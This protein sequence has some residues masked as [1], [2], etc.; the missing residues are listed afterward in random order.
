MIPGVASLYQQIVQV[1]WNIAFIKE[2]LDDILKGCPLH[3]HFMSHSFTD[4][5][6][7][8]PF[9]LSVDNKHVVLLAEEYS[10]NEHKGNIVRLVVNRKDYALD[11]RQMI[12]CH[13]SH[14]SFPQIVRNGNDFQILPENTSEGNVSLFD[15]SGKR[16]SVLLPF[17]LHDALLTSLFGKPQIWG[18]PNH[19]MSGNELEVYEKMPTSYQLVQKI[20]FTDNIARNAGDFFRVGNSIYRPGQICN[21]LYGEGVC[22]Q[23][24]EQNAG[25]LHFREVRR[26]LPPSPYV[27]L[28]TFNA[29]HGVVVTD[30]H[31]IR[32]TAFSR[33]MFNLRHQII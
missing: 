19:N 25:G 14:V 30:V 22:L 9:I 6:F 4:R 15:S 3:F 27:G 23:R 11:D 12:L 10:L 2:G 5:W 32:Q 24:V 18:T 1:A 29:Y 33:M 7:A 17:P 31:S 21:K 26:I 13:S 8:D 16:V 20:Q 28:H